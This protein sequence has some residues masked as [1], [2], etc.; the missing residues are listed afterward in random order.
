MPAHDR[1]SPRRVCASALAGLALLAVTSS[2]ACATGTTGHE[3]RYASAACTRYAA[4]WGS[5]RS[6]GTFAHPFRGVRRLL[7]SLRPGQTGCLRAGIYRENLSL[8]HG[9]SPVRPITLRS[10]PGEGAR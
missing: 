9:G 8:R 3:A 2:A 10:S 1:V 4:P 6:R 5:N 7:L